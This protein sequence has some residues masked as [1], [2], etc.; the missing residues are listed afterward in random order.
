MALDCGKRLNL[1]GLVSWQA[2]F[3][4]SMKYIFTYLQNVIGNVPAVI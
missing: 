3:A 4:E 1:R 2:Y